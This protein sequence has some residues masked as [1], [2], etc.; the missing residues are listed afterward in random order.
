MLTDNT[1]ALVSNNKYDDFQQT[2]NSVLSYSL[3][4]NG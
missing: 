3:C 2:L 1:I 4:L